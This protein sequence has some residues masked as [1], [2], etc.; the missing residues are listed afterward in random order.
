MN[1]VMRV[2]FPVL[3]VIMMG[4]GLEKKARKTFINGEYQSTIEIG[5]KILLKNARSPETNYYIGESYRLSNRLFLAEPYYKAAIDKGYKSD[6]LRLYYAYALKANGKYD[7]ART[8]LNV[9]S[10]N[11]SNPGLKKRAEDELQNISYLDELRS[12]PSYYR[13]RNLEAIN[14]SFAEY[15]PAYRENELYF[16]SNRGSSKIYK[17]TGTP[18]SNIFKAQTRGANVDASTVEALHEFINSVDANEGSVTFSPDGTRMVFARGNTGKKKGGDEVNLFMSTYRN[19]LWTEPRPLN[20]NDPKAWDSCP[21]FSPDGKTLYFASNR[22]P[23]PNARRSDVVNYGGI[24]IYSA[25]MDARGRFSKPRNLGPEINTPGNELFPYVAEDGNMY[26]SSDGHPGFGGLDLFVSKRINGRIIIENLGQPMNSKADDFG[27]YFFRADRGFFSSNRDGGKGDDDIYT[28]VNED[29]DLKIVNYLLAGTTQTHDDKN[30]IQI[31]PRVKVQLLD[32]AGKLVDETITENDGKFLFRVY[33]NETYNLVA[34]KVGGMDRFLVTRGI[35]TMKGKEV[36]KTTLKDLVNT[37]TQD[38]VLVLEKIIKDKIFV[39]DNIYYDLD[40]DNIRPDAALE[41]DKLVTIL[42]D[43]PEIK[44][45]LSSHTDD[46][47]P[48]DYNMDLS[49]R[50]ARSAV[51]YLVSKG[52]DRS[53]LVAKGYGES[54]LIIK[55][56]KTEEEHQVNRRTE[57]KIL[58]IGQRKR[59]EEEE[60]E[61]GAEEDEDDRFFRGGN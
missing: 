52:I 13:V 61:F 57:F 26:F 8:Q 59:L 36:D 16:T 6:S 47:A 19:G 31:L 7:E 51:N 21:A 5:E 41:L 20:I 9:L 12:K 55:N 25:K 10:N 42:K 22:K 34:E 50:R 45:E 17:A 46:R 60:E 3:V 33:E 30:S 43:N 56:A 40:K 1:R 14:T 37:I 2:L 4:C 32:E 48:D 49:D 18:F 29:P 53:R 28:F 35:Y 38:T 23:D 54:R 24:D 39:L 15:G 27:I 58:E 44:I 11:D